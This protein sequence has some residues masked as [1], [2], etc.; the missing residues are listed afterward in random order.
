MPQKVLFNPI[1][2]SMRYRGTTRTVAGIIM[3][4]RNSQKTRSLP[5]KSMRA[6]A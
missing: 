6:K 1:L 4:A 3:V 2:A 5:G